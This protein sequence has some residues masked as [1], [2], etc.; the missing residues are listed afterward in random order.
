[1]GMRLLAVINANFANLQQR[2][3]RWNTRLRG[4]G[5]ALIVKAAVF[6]LQGLEKFLW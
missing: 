4:P 2:G 5:A 3:N 1:M 6:G